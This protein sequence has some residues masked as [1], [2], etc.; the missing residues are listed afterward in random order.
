MLKLIPWKIRI[1]GLVLLAGL[2]L[3]LVWPAPAHKMQDSPAH[4]ERVKTSCDRKAGCKCERECDAT[5]RRMP[6]GSVDECPAF[7]CESKCLCHGPCP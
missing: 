5:G 3:A 2:L 4:C 1:G 6:A 7:C